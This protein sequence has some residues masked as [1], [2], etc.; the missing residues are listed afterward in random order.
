MIE[1]T[2]TIAID[3]AG[4]VPQG[5]STGNFVYTPALLR[6]QPGDRIK[7]QSA[8]PFVVTFKGRTPVESMEVV[9]KAMSADFASD[10]A[11]VQENARGNYHY[12]VAVFDGSRVFMDADCPH[13]SVN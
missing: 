2:I 5:G 8:V 10:F 3:P 1:Y 11:C 7:W 9:G 4:I 6:V 13:I 12:A